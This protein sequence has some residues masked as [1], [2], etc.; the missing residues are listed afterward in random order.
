M[1]FR[2]ELVPTEAELARSEGRD[3][4]PAS[5]L[6]ERARLE[7]INSAGSPRRRV[8]LQRTRSRVS[9]SVLRFPTLPDA[10][11]SPVKAARHRSI[12]LIRTTFLFVVAIGRK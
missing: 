7:R 8:S 6:L 2:D 4:E 12:A 9:R 10:S 1:T 3:N 5:V 11:A